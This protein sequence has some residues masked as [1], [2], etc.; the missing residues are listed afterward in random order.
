[1]SVAGL[2][3]NRG[4][5]TLGHIK[6]GA[7]ESMAKHISGKKN[8]FLSSEVIAALNLYDITSFSSL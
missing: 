2:A 4:W 6:W 7:G 5:C 3:A 1:M 8:W